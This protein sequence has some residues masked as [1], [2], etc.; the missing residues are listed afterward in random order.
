MLEGV[1]RPQP[2]E[3]E[4]KRLARKKLEQGARNL[5]IHAQ[6]SHSPTLD[7]SKNFTKNDEDMKRAHS[8]IDE[9]AAE[10][11]ENPHPKGSLEWNVWNSQHYIRPIREQFDKDRKRR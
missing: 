9:A 5:I 1:Q 4:A 3:E 6:W 7:K 11:G 2:D 10:L 8:Q